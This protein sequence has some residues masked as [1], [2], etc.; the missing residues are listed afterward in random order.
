[1][2]DSQDKDGFAPLMEVPEQG[3]LSIVQYLCEHGAN[4][5]A[6]D[7]N[8]KKKKLHDILLHN[9]IILMVLNI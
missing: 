6:K 5:E 1:M 2:I 8:I 7:N 3:H 4:K 9:K